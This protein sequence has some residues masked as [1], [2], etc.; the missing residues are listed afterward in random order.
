MYRGYL[1][2]LSDSLLD[3]LLV[4][5]LHTDHTKTENYNEPDQ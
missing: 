3:F 2:E 5:L 4:I 1:E